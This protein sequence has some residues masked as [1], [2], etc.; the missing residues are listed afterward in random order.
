VD[1]SAE[2]LFSGLVPPFLFPLAGD[3]EVSSGGYFCYVPMPF[4]KRCKIRIGG[5]LL[6][7]NIDYYR[8]TEKEDAATFTGRKD[9]TTALDLL[10]ASGSNPHE[11]TDEV[12]SREGRIS[13]G[14]GEE[15]VFFLEQGPAWILQLRLRPDD[16]SASGLSSV[17]IKGRWDRA[18]EPQL[19]APLFS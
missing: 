18:G 13:L 15:Q 8:F 10:T 11:K 19:A 12:R 14:P 7:Y 4:R 17:W 6:Y 3:R 16:L 5:A 9:N 1:I 2:D